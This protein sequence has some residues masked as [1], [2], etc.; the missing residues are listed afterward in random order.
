MQ[1]KR[2]MLKDFCWIAKKSY[3]WLKTS[4]KKAAEIDEINTK[5]LKEPMFA[6]FGFK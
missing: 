2:L 1:C 5:K 6:D 4:L 3:T